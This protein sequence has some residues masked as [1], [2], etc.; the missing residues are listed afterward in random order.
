MSLYAELAFQT[1]EGVFIISVHL[2]ICPV[3]TVTNSF[4]FA[5]WVVTKFFVGVKNSKVFRP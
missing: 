5:K 2:L 1:L 4:A 3:K